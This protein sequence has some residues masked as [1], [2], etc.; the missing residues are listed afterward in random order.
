MI[1][2]GLTTFGPGF[3]GRGRL[4]VTIFRCGPRRALRNF[5][6]SVIRN[7]VR[8]NLFDHG[9]VSFVVLVNDEKQHGLWPAFTDVRRLTVFRVRRRAPSVWTILNGIGPIYGRRVCV[10]S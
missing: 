1:L 2:K 10:R 6:L 9:S 8:R 5:L 3:G 7:S 4:G